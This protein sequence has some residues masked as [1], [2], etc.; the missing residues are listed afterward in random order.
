MYGYWKT[1]FLVFFGA[2]VLVL[3]IACINVGSLMLV[4]ASAREK[5]M[6]VRASLGAGQPR[7]IRQLLTE[8]L[9]IIVLGLGMAVLIAF[10]AVRLISG[11]DPTLLPRAASIRINLR[12]LGFAAF[13]AVVSGL[14]TGLAPAVSA[15][16]PNLN[17]A[18]KEAGRTAPRFGGRKARSAL[19][20]LEIALSLVLLTGAGLLIDDIRRLL[21][22]SLGFDS[23]NLVMM[24][25]SLPM[26]QYLVDD[27]KS[28]TLK[29]QAVLVRQ[30]I[31]E[32]LQALPGVQSVSVSTL[33]PLE[34]CSI[35]YVSRE[36]DPLPSVGVNTPWVCLQ[37]VTTEYFRTLQTPVVRGRP[38]TEQD[39]Q[40]A[41]PAVVV[42]ERLV[43]RYFPK[44]DP[45]GKVLNLMREEGDREPS[46]QI[47]GVVPDLR[48]SLLRRTYAAI[49][50]PYSQMSA[51]FGGAHTRERTDIV[52]LVRT[53]TKPSNLEPV[54]RRV[55][56][57]AARDVPVI[58]LRTI[59]EIRSLR[60]QR[61]NLYASLLTVFAVMAVMLASVGVFGVMSYTVGQRTR[62]IGIRVA[63]GARPP[64]VV[65]AVM[66]RGVFLI[67]TGLA[68]GLAGSLCA[69]RFLTK[70]LFEVKPTDPRIL[71]AVTLFLGLVALL[72]CLIP[73]R[74]A[75]R[76]T[77]VVALRHE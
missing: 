21:H 34:G 53:S 2:V 44:E 52:Y 51:H 9:L 60:V 39:N 49:Y 67:I 28:R 24:R 38:F 27:G 75:L 71:F 73:V 57:E 13:T 74:R 54:M 58:D 65:G 40:R 26:F 48:Q 46:V 43:T 61:S 77:P 56:S 18:L 17:E 66:R 8:N 76:V 33:S 37:P 5:E 14:L 20:V 12:V 41:P 11:I 64:D 55:V 72:A 4:R 23:R 16:K 6:A 1:R 70:L 42:N 36:N 45:I 7:L 30:R 25:I 22:V 35:R 63:L 69:T 19:V 68:A 15:S 59:D 29:P 47:V 62:E 50:L 10:M 31:H 3:S 32:R